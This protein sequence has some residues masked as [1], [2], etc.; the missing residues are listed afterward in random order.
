[1]W[2]WLPIIFLI[3]WIVKSFSKI[4]SKFEKNVQMEVLEKERMRVMA[5]F[6]STLYFILSKIAFYFSWGKR[7]KLLQRIN[8]S[9]SVLINITIFSKLLKNSML[10]SSTWFAQEKERERESKMD[11][12]NNLHPIF[13]KELVLGIW[14][15]HIKLLDE[16]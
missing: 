8:K 6:F 16:I 1:M 7:I 12:T 15:R 13:P 5:L 2:E 14:R 10:E 4:N 11:K 3:D 9:M